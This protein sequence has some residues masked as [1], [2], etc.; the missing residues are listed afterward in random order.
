[1]NEQWYIKHFL[2]NIQSIAPLEKRKTNNEKKLFLIFN[3]HE[4]EWKNLSTSNYL[5]FLILT[6][7]TSILVLPGPSEKERKLHH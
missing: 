2:H 5:L 1:M 4:K 7:E 6:G 3:G